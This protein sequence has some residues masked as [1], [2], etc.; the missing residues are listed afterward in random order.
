[1]VEKVNYVKRLFKCPWCGHEF[2]EGISFGS[3]VQCKGC[4]I[5]LPNDSSMDVT[6][7][8]N[9]LNRLTK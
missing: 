7:V 1:M 4:T 3:Q 5:F 8:R 9:A 6:N 2:E